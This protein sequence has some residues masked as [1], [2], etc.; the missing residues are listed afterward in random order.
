MQ[1]AVP[2]MQVYMAKLEGR[3]ATLELKLPGLVMVARRKMMPI[4]PF[5]VDVVTMYMMV[6][7]K[8]QTIAKP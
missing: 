1:A 6:W 8:A 3:Y 7:H 2:S 4:L 5:N